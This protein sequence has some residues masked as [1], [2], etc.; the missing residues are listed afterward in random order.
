M[1]PLAIPTTPPLPY[2]H[3]TPTKE[4][5]AQLKTRQL[6]LAEHISTIEEDLPHLRDIIDKNPIIQKQIDHIDKQLA[7]SLKL[8]DACKRYHIPDILIDDYESLADKKDQLEQ[9]LIDEETYFR[10]QKKIAALEEFDAN[11]QKICEYDIKK[12]VTYLSFVFK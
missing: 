11:D 5:Y 3:P 2:P 4:E 12:V 10:T 9:Q 7:D 6:I 1:N 8:M